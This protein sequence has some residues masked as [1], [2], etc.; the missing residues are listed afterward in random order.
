MYFSVPLSE[1]TKPI[2]ALNY[3]FLRAQHEWPAAIAVNCD[4]T[5]CYRRI[6]HTSIVSGYTIYPNYDQYL[7]SCLTKAAVPSV[8]VSIEGRTISFEPSDAGSDLA[9]LL[10]ELPSWSYKVEPVDG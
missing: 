4:G 5:V 9:T 2:D 3:T 6:S 1:N 8:A 7:T 10:S